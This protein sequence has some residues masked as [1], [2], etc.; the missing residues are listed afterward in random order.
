MEKDDLS[1]NP[2]PSE[3][4]QEHISE[5]AMPI[6]D[7][8]PLPEN[9]EADNPAWKKAQDA[10]RS[11]GSGFGVASRPPQQQIEQQDTSAYYAWP[12]AAVQFQ[13]QGGQFNAYFQQQQVSNFQPSQYRPRV[14]APSPHQSPNN[15][16]VLRPVPLAQVSPH[17][18]AGFCAFYLNLIIF[19]L[20]RFASLFRSQAI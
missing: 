9:P 6:P 2:I 10:L 17:G 5:S 18:Q 11:M 15:M 12:P 19:S 1:I 8:I 13:Q 16:N 7:D 3:S 20:C 14:L 4:E